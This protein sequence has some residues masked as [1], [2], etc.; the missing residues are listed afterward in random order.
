M[1]GP[2]SMYFS[3]GLQSAQA[4]VLTLIWQITAAKTI[5]PVPLNFTVLTTFDGFSAQSQI[6]NFLGTSSEFL[7]AD[8]DAGTMGAN[9]FACLVNMQG[10]ASAASLMRTTIYSTATNSFDTQTLAGV[11]ES[12]LSNASASEFQVGA[13][14]NMAFKVLA[15]GLDAL[16]AGA[17]VTDLFWFP[18]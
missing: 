4:E 10:Q 2:S 9:M 6:D 11:F 3:P 13:Y 8:L 1:S 7:L 16:T 12:A 14:G 17:I 18:V 5:V 15:T